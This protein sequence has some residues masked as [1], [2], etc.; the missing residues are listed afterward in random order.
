MYVT[1]PGVE[2]SLWW[3]AFDTQVTHRWSHMSAIWRQGYCVRI[4]WQNCKTV[5][6]FCLLESW[7]V[8]PLI[9]SDR[10]CTELCTFMSY[11]HYLLAVTGKYRRFLF[12]CFILEFLSIFVWL[13]SW[14]LYL[15]MSPSMAT[16]ISS[17]LLTLFNRSNTATKKP[18]VWSSAPVRMQ[19]SPAT[20]KK[21]CYWML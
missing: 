3:P 20:I 2:C 1:C 5:G 11:P 8:I 6:F 15:W 9:M 10:T 13:C 18:F 7:S 21:S 12:L 14:V 19:W 16:V 17:P 4:L